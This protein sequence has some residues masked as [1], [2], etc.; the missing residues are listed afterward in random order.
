VRRRPDPNKPG[1]GG[2][3]AAIWFAIVRD[4]ASRGEPGHFVTRDEG[5]WDGEK[6]KRA[7][8]EDIPEAAEPLTLHKN[9][10]SFL[11]R[12][13]EQDEVEVDP[14]DVQ[15]GALPFIKSGLERS[16][17][18]P[19][20]VFDQD[21]HALEFQTEVTDGKIER[22]ERAQR[23]VGDLGEILLI[24]AI[25]RLDFR[26][27]YRERQPP[28]DTLW[29]VVDELDASGQVQVYL[30]EPGSE[31]SGGQFIAA[32]LKPRQTAWLSGTALMTIST[33]DE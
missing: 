17:L 33:L 8:A 24:D 29:F 28:D 22:V 21:F 26:L 2:R 1:A 16:P 32:Q 27:L 18:L 3:D 11:I 13:G 15:A 10:E 23:F 30:G 19:R 7:L 31:T 5:F 12:L 9:V 25:W 4:H 6:M 14:E 20:A